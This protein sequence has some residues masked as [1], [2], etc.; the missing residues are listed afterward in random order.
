MFVRFDNRLQPGPVLV[1]LRHRDVEK[2][3]RA[4][5]IGKLIQVGRGKRVRHLASTVGAEVVKD[6]RVVVVNGADG[7]CVGAGAI[8]DDDGLDEFVGDAAFVAS[9]KRGDRIAGM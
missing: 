6:D 7:F 5:G 2:T 3:F 8:G 1:V 9:A 4:L